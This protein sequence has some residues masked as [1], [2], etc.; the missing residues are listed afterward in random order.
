VDK[1]Y[2]AYSNAALAVK[3]GTATPDQ[4]WMVEEMAKVAGSKGQEARDALKNAGKG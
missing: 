4:I 3:A 1:S 2:Q